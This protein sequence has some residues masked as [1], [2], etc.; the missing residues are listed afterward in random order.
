MAEDCWP[1]YGGVLVSFIQIIELLLLASLYL[2]LGGYLLYGLFPH[3]QFSLRLW[4]V[5]ASCVGLPTL[6]IKHLSQVAWFSLLSISALTS[7]IIIILGYGFTTY[8]QWDISKIALWDTKGAPVAL[9]VIVFSYISHPILP[10]IESNMRNPRQFNLI[11]GIT[12]T[13][14]FI[15]K[16]TFAL[17]GYLAF[18]SNMNE[19]ITNSISLRPVRIVVNCLLIVNSLCS[20]PFHMKTTIHCI[21]DSISSESLRSKFDTMLWYVSIRIIVSLIVLL[22]AIV[23][24]QFALM[25]SFV[26]SLTSMFIV[27]IFPCIFHLWLQSEYL[28]WYHKVLD[29][30]I[31]VFGFAFGG[32]GLVVS[33]IDIF[34]QFQ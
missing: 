17:L 28:R 32:I 10:T 14:I 1:K 27:F 18:S 9:M 34:R 8:H 23:I 20:Y 24:P 3:G 31:I 11:L 29:Y 25:M 2:V 4:I 21:Q 33:T 13:L 26:S 30:F 7:A 22:P 6:F 5:L 19:E 16:I 15:I 12:Y